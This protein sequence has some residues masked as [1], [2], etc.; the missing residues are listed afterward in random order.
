MAQSHNSLANTLTK[1][2]KGEKVTAKA[3]G[4]LIDIEGV[5]VVQ[6][7]DKLQIQALQTWMDPLE[8]F[9]QIAPNGIVNRQAMNRK[10]DPAD[11]LDETSEASTSSAP[12]QV[13]QGDSADAA[14]GR[15]NNEEAQL[16][17][18]AQEGPAIVPAYEEKQSKGFSQ[19]ETSSRQNLYPGPK[20]EAQAIVETAAAHG[21]DRS[22][23][24]VPSNAKQPTEVV[25]PIESVPIDSLREDEAPREVPRSIYSSAVTGN[26]E[27]ILKP[28]KHG[29]KLD[30]SKSA[31]VHDAVDEHL[32]GPAEQVHPQPKDIEDGVKPRP[33]EAVVAEPGS[34]ETRMTHEEMSNMAAGECPFLMNRE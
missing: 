2:S 18:K 6:V 27:D 29:K 3:H 33:G 14:I 34:Q 10:V 19:D 16:E 15:P 21:D 4:G 11:A 32:E 22:V 8:M 28:A 17:H 9:R 23:E 31:G 7:N 26:K 12:E 5:I 25:P 20:S 1:Y 13:M 30:E 24:T